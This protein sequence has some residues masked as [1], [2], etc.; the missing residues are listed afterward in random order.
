[1]NCAFFSLS[2]FLSSSPN[3]HLKTKQKQKS[4]ASALVVLIHLSVLWTQRVQPGTLQLAKLA[5]KDERKKKKYVLFCW[6]LWQC[7]LL[8]W[9]KRKD[10]QCPQKYTNW[11]VQV[12][13]KYPKCL[14]LMCIFPFLFCCVFWHLWSNTANPSVADSFL[15]IL[16]EL[17]TG[18]CAWVIVS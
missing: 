2:F 3:R 1:M 17:H 8:S 6:T 9:G 15:R 18:V 4:P 10:M 5:A 11:N 7:T 13:L 14:H 16:Y 12:R